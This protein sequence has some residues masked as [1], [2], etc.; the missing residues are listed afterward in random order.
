MRDAQNFFGEPV[1]SGTYTGG[2]V[3][4]PMKLT[5]VMKP[6]TQQRLEHTPPEFGAFVLFRLSSQE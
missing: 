3:E 4:L 1:L 6:V 2:V 5:E